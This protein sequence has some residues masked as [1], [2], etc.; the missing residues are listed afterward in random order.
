[1][2]RTFSFA[3]IFAAALSSLCG[4]DKPNVLFIPVDDLNHWVGHLGRNKQTKTPNIDRLAA[5]GV[6]FTNA[7]CAAPVCNPSRT[8]LLSGL[9]PGT[10]GIYVNGVHFSKGAGVSAEGSLVTQFKH[11]GYETLGIGKLWHGGL[12][13]PEQ[14]SATGG[15]LRAVRAPLENRSIGGIQFGV[16]DG[17]DESVADTAIADYAIA[18]LGKKHDRPFFLVPGFH[19]PHMPWNVPR[20]YYVLHPLESIELPPIKAD[21]LADI[22]PAGIKMARPTGDHA[23]VLASGRWKEAIQGYLAAISYLDAQLGRIL[24]A[25]EKS[26]YRDNTII[27]FFGDHGWHFGEKE[28]WRKFALWEESTRAPFI[29][30]V[31]GVTKAGGV[32]ERSVDFMSI[33]PTLCALAGI[34]KPG[35]VVGENLRPL[36]VDPKAEWKKPALTTFGQNNHAIRTET[37]RYIRYANGDEELYDHRNDPYEWTNLAAQPEFAAVKK[38]LAAFLPSE[39]VPAVKGRRDLEDDENAGNDVQGEPRGKRRARRAA[40]KAASST[41]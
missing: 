31:P 9:R 25:L 7:H 26:E 12:G 13:F 40:A 5:M 3:I 38:E 11:A 41:N 15:R 30:V 1:M 10:T 33:Y 22:P 27:C 17:G 21:D 23:R 36:L 4:A 32:C 39:N 35:H 14:W 29:W 2:K 34:A 18:E 37:W 19:K 16:L 28:H 8:A 20:K 6:T 24:D